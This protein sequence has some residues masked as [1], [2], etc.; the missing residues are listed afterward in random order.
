MH[1]VKLMVV[2]KLS[3]RVLIYN[4]WSVLGSMFWL[5]LLADSKPHFLGQACMTQPPSSIVEKMDV[6]TSCDEL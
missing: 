2:V 1:L 3:T 4:V 5:W 6:V